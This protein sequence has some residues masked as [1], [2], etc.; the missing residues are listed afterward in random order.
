VRKKV[1]IFISF[2]ALDRLSKLSHLEFRN[3]TLW[4]D[5]SL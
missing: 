1:S 5:Y 3:V 2:F 4:I